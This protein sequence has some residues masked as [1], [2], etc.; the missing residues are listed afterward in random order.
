MPGFARTPIDFRPSRRESSAELD[1]R[2]AAAN[3][4]RL[5][6]LFATA[7]T[8]PTHRADVRVLFGKYLPELGIGTDLVAVCTDSPAPHRWGG[9]R[10]ISRHARSA[11]GGMLA[12]A[13]LQVSLLWRCR[14]GYDG[15]IVRDKPFLGMLGLAAARL[16]RIPFFYWM[17][18]PMPESDLAISGS[19]DGSV[20]AARRVYKWMRGRAGTFALYRLILPSADHVFVQSPL[21]LEHARARGLR[22]AR[23]SAVPMGVDL[24][25][26]P[27]G[28]GASGGV[29]SGRRVAVYLG[30]LSMLRRR[31]LETMIDAALEV[32][33]TY[34]EFEL[35]VIGES[36][37]ADEKGWLQRYA[38]ARGAT[39]CVRFLGWVPYDKGLRLASEASVGV[40]PVPRGELFDMGSPTKAIEYMALRL[41]VVCN[42]QPDQAQVIRDSGGGF[43]VDLSPA[44]FAAAIVQLLRDPDSAVRMGSAGHDWVRQHRDYRRL[45]AEV[46]ATLRSG[47]QL[48]E[49]SAGRR[50]PPAD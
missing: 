30:T 50:L 40:S 14:R 43:C 20:R 34:P 10:L 25:A 2:A 22:H 4:G 9:G 33:K 23:V 16:A 7:E 48:R 49:A 26:L 46:A 15:L 42:D 47:C 12:D 11:L 35:L 18:F 38:E 19:S 28:R 36:E 32:E 41:P 6:F 29:P 24:D 31:E 21:M 17:S 5:R 13:A 45:A 39:R 44:A 3:S 1:E 37:S 8:H 27:G